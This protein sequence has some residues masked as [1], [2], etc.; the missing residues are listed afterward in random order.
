MGTVIGI[1]L[2]VVFVACIVVAGVWFVRTKRLNAKGQGG[3]A[4][5]NPSYLREV[6]MDHIQDQSQVN[7][8][9]TS[10]IF[11]F[12]FHFCIVFECYERN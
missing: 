9:A 5:E 4:F 1:I 2:A 12:F 10:V 3:V 7:G 11:I 8:V 6:N